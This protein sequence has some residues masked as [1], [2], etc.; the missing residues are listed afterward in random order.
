MALKRSNRLEI[1]SSE[2]IE[3]FNPSEIVDRMIDLRC[4]LAKL[5]RQ[6][7]DLQPAFFA[8]CLALN[9]D[10]IA[11]ERAVIS[12]RLTPGRWLYSPDIIEGE[13][14]IKQLKREFQQTHE[15]S[16][17]RE[18]TWFIKLLLLTA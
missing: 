7:Q 6:I 5:E 2:P 10:T 15:P 16:G 14:L 9:T 11:L 18:V 4:Q 8:A 3:V 12:R 17:G 1:S 13:G